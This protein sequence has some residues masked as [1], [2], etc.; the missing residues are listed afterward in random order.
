MFSFC[1]CAD[2]ILS[3]IAYYFPDTEHQSFLSSYNFLWTYPIWQSVQ[4][5][6]VLKNICVVFPV[7][8]AQYIPPT[9]ILSSCPSLLYIHGPMGIFNIRSQNFWVNQ[10]EKWENILSIRGWQLKEELPISEGGLQWKWALKH[11]TASSVERCFK[12]KTFDL[13]VR[14]SE[15]GQV[16]QPFAW[17]CGI[18]DIIV[19]LRVGCGSLPNFFH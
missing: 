4:N 15:S 2:F 10:N 13:K 9:Q 12:D 18:K 5:Y 16:G 1:F 19:Y 11:S 8:P 17:D 6:I 3:M 7:V 14:N